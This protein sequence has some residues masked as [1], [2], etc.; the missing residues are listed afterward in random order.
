MQNHTLYSFL[1]DNTRKTEVDTEVMEV[2]HQ[3]NVEQQPCF[4]YFCSYKQW[5]QFMHAYAYTA[6]LLYSIQG[7]LQV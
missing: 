5:Q 3:Y 1:S 2:Y 4:S 7:Q 6:I